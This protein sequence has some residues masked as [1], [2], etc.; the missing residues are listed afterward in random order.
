MQ[1]DKG[2]RLSKGI[3]D[4]RLNVHQRQFSEENNVELMSIQ[5]RRDLNPEDL[6]ERH[7]I[8]LP[9]AL[10][11][12]IANPQFFNHRGLLLLC[13]LNKAVINV[14][15]SFLKVVAEKQQRESNRRQNGLHLP[16]AAYRDPDT[17]LPISPRR[18]LDSH[19]I[20]I[21]SHAVPAKIHV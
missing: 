9:E 18:Q 20:L 1:Q 2:N 3:S 8:L 7:V 17:G 15:D 5:E 6:N 10:R 21:Y 14:V 12:T 13:C 16:R 19:L 11:V 4:A